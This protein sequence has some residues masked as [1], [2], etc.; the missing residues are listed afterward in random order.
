MHIV[1]MKSFAEMIQVP[2]NPTDV[3]AKPVDD[4]AV[5]DVGEEVMLI[6]LVVPEVVGTHAVVVVGMVI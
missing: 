2:T 6:L 5:K 3:L 1:G 4:I